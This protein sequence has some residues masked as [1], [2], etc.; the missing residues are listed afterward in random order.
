MKVL[1]DTNIILDVLLNRSAFSDNSKAIFDLAEKKQIIGH[2]SASA[3]TDIFYIAYKEYKNSEKVY[4]A[5]DKLIFLFSIIPVTETTIAN[6]LTLRWQDFEDAV[7][8]TAA[9]ENS[10]KYII[11]HNKADYKTAGIRCMSPSDFIIYFQ[12][13]QNSGV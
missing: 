2:I 4:Q 9:D 3:M 5:I 13:Q 1:I 10:L 12:N 8:Y 6:A 7:Q 11:T